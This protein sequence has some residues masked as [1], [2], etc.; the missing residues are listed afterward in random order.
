MSFTFSYPQVK[1]MQPFES[2]VVLRF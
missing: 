1:V 2:L